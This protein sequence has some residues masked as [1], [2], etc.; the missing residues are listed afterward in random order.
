MYRH[1][2][3][4]LLTK[5]QQQNVGLIAISVGLISLH[6]HCSGCKQYSNTNLLYTNQLEKEVR[7]KTD[8]QTYNNGSSTYILD[9]D[10]DNAMP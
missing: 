9:S 7:D 1:E 5:W 8:R 3:L 4:G 2:S 10:S 6:S